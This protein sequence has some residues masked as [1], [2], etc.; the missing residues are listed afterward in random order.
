MHCMTTLTTPS[1]VGSA[2]FTK[3]LC[4]QNPRW[5]RARPSVRPSVVVSVRPSVRRSVGHCVRPSAGPSVTVSVRPSLLPSPKMVL[6]TNQPSRSRT[7]PCKPT[8]STEGQRRCQDA[9][10]SAHP[11]T[12]PIA[13]PCRSP[14]QSATAG[15][16]TSAPDVR[17]PRW[18][19]VSGNEA[20]PESAHVYDLRQALQRQ[21]A[22][23]VARRLWAGASPLLS[24]TL[25][26]GKLSRSADPTGTAERES[27]FGNG[28]APPLPNAASSSCAL[29]FGGVG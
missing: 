11:E 29:H 20:V 8:A 27:T 25:F 5:T 18:P 1:A 24:H 22:S 26:S 3:A 23:A 28:V 14:K 17:A 12:W 13:G 9:C 16:N 6:S 21:R 4:A 7:P 10:R 2:R 19:T 15:C